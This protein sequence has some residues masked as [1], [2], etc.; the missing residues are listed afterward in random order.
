MPKVTLPLIR[1]LVHPGGASLAKR[2]S[3]IKEIFNTTNASQHDPRWDSA[4]DPLDRTRKV[5][6]S[7][8]SRL[9][10]IEDRIGQE[11]E[12]I[13]AAALEEAPA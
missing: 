2:I 6:E 11:I 10:E 12:T 7:D 3:G 8:P 4:Y 9:R 1:S 13:L 5:L